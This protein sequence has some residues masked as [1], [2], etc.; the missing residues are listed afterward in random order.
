MDLYSRK[1]VGWSMRDTLEAEI[2]SD[3]LAMA[4]ARRRPATGVIHHSDRGSQGR[5]QSV[6]ATPE[7]E[8]LR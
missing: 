8:E 3:A 7:R 2:V 5:I 1:I 4:V 6:V